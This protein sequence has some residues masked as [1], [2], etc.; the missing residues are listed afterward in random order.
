MSIVSTY[1]NILSNF[2]KYRIDY[3]LRLF[4]Y[5]CKLYKVKTNVYSDVYGR[6][7]GE[8]LSTP[9]NITLL[10]VTDTFHPV[11]SNSAGTLTEGWVFTDTSDLSVGDRIELVRHDGLNRLFRVDSIHSLGQ[12]T[13]VISKYRIVALAD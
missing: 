5:K 1:E 4:G 9:I 10:V 3:L 12:Y 7:A 13:T 8:E 11:D 2:T 6:D